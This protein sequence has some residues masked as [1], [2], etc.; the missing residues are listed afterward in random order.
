MTWVWFALAAAFLWAIT[1]I[2][3]RIIHEKY[4][5]SSVLTVV[6]LA[7]FEMVVTIPFLPAAHWASLDANAWIL[8]FASA[9]IGL[10]AT[11]FYFQAIVSHEVSRVIPTFQFIPVFTLLFAAVLFGEALTERQG[12]AF[13]VIFLGV[14]FLSIERGSQLKVKLSR[15][16]LLALISSA[17]FAIANVILAQARNLL[18]DTLTTFIGMQIATFILI[19][20]Y[21]MLAPTHLRMLFHEFKTIGA[22]KTRWYALSVAGS[23]LGYAIF[24]AALPLAPIALISVLGGIQP[25]FV[26]L[27]AA[28]F[29]I[30]APGII[31]EDIGYRVV[32]L[33]VVALIIIFSGAYL[34][35][36]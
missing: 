16:F 36:V 6:V 35:F 30:F 11:V 4:I 25:F 21:L 27:L 19:V 2:A 10:V 7:I 9:A 1:N 5:T 31:R 12:I 18:P 8:L 13:A 34:L 28:L 33:K 14:L 22:K 26:F 24:I 29:T 20:F 3:D 23:M 17:F 32:I 15:A